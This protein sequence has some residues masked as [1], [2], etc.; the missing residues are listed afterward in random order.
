MIEQKD[1]DTVIFPVKMRRVE[2]KKLNI[3]CR[4]VVGTKMGTLTKKLLTKE[5]GIVFVDNRGRKVK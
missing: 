5:T 4:D 3:Y 2:K 1:E